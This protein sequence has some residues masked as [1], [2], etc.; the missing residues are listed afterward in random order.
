MSRGGIDA[1][2]ATDGDF[3]IFH[4]DKTED[5]GLIRL[6]PDLIVTVQVRNCALSRS[7]DHDTGTGQGSALIII[8]DTADGDRLAGVLVGIGLDGGGPGGHGDRSAEQRCCQAETS[9][10]LLI[11]NQAGRKASVR[12]APWEPGR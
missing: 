7:L 6:D 10:E 3:L 9:N 11:H 4:S 5:Q 2:S 8:D 12:L 1:G